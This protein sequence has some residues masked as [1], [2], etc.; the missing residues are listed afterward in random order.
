MATQLVSKTSQ[1]LRNKLGHMLADSGD[2]HVDRKEGNGLQNFEKLQAEHIEVGLLLEQLKSFG[3]S[4][5]SVSGRGFG[6][7]DTILFN[8]RIL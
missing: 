3:F 7:T 2:L 8:T 6:F 5:G 1:L 4:A